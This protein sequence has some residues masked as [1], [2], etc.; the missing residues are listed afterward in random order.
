MWGIKAELLGRHMA[1]S[2]IDLHSSEIASYLAMT[3]FYRFIQSTISQQKRLLEI[4]P[5]AFDRL[6]NVFL[7][8]RQTR[9]HA[10]LLRGTISR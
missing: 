6:N 5:E 4:N 1:L 3:T 8:H 10:H 7:I 9:G 2:S